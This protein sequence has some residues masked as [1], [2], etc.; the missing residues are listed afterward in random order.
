[1]LGRLSSMGRER[2]MDTEPESIH[3]RVPGCHQV[4]RF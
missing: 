1:M 4:L 3:Q 2:I